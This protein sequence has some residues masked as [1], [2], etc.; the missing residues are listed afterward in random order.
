MPELGLAGSG[1]A[2]TIVSFLMLFALVAY[3]YATP[4]F[5]GYGLFRGRLKFDMSV[6]AEIVRLGIPV[7]GIVILEASLFMAVSLFSGILGP[8]PLATY[9]VMMAWV[10]IAFVTAHGLAEAGMLRIAHSIG[11]GSMPA[12]RQAGVL[13]F[14]IGTIWLAVLAIVPVLF[15]HV[16]VGAFLDANDPGFDD[17]LTMTTRLLILAAFFQVF[18]GLQLMATLAWW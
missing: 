14:T 2:K 4:V 18:D 6:C 5:R 11:A 9:Q 1:W 16:L 13:T 12:A 10:G 15:P 8:I 3:T 7:A 17:V